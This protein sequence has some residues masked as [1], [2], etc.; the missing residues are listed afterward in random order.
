MWRSEVN[1]GNETVCVNLPITENV[2][3]YFTFEKLPFFLSVYILIC[4]Q[5]RYQNVALR[6]VSPN[7]ADVSNYL[8][9]CIFILHVQYIYI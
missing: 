7:N 2:I 8:R 9:G 6:Y 1:F 3:S 5:L 4:P